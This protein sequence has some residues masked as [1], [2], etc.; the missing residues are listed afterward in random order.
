MRMFNIEFFHEYDVMMS[1]FRSRKGAK[2]S[3]AWK[4]IKFQTFNC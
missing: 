4:I 3:A 1:R 2:L